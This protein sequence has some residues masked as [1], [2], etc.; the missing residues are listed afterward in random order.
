MSAISEMWLYQCQVCEFT[1]EDDESIMINH[2][3]IDHVTAIR[4]VDGEKV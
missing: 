2:M 3:M 4:T 1:V